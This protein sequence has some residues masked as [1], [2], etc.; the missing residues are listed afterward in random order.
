MTQASG[1]ENYLSFSLL[2]SADSVFASQ[3]IL[4]DMCLCKAC[5]AESIVL[6]KAAIN[7]FLCH[8]SCVI[9][10]LKLRTLSWHN[11]LCEDEVL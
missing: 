6:R 2:N 3:L 5:G 1:G 11:M 10:L 9:Y 4:V 8:V 7:D